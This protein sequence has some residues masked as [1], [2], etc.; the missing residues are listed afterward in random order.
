MER[1]CY[2]FKVLSMHLEDKGMNRANVISNTAVIFDLKVILLN[3]SHTC[4]QYDYYSLGLEGARDN[5]E[6]FKLAAKGLG[7]VVDIK[8]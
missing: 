3:W 6:M 7:A 4:G 8:M 2:A 1:F 5:Y